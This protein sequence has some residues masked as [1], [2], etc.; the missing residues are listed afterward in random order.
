MNKRSRR[1][2]LRRI[3][4]RRRT[5][6]I[7]R[8]SARRIVPHRRSRRR[9]G[10]LFGG[11]FLSQ[12]SNLLLTGYGN[13]SLVVVLGIVC[14]IFIGLF[15]YFNRTQTRRIRVIRGQDSSPFINEG[16]TT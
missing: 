7:S 13:I 6:R 4:S 14:A 12:L 9:R 15:C 16:V 8:K 10:S 3:S 5:R 2:T 1:R 11:S